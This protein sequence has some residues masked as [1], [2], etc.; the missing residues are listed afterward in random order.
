MLL[1][2]FVMSTYRQVSYGSLRYVE[3]SGFGLCNNRKPAGIVVESNHTG[4]KI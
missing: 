1:L 3:F 2:G 4:F